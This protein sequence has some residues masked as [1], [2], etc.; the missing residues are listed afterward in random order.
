MDKSEDHLIHK[1]STIG[2]EKIFLKT[3]KEEIP[4]DLDEFNI[5]RAEIDK[6]ESIIN[7]IYKLIDIFLIKNRDL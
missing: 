5:C 4:E 2:L 1:N 7:Y 6:M 3:Y